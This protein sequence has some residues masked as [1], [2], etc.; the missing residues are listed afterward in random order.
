MSTGEYGSELVNVITG[1]IDT[2]SMRDVTQ[3]TIN[4]GSNFLGLNPQVDSSTNEFFPQQSG[5][6][7]YGSGHDTQ[8][9]FAGG[10]QGYQPGYIYLKEGNVYSF[11]IRFMEGGGSQRF[12]FE[13]DY[14]ED[15]S[16]SGS[17]ED[18]WRSIDGIVSVPSSGPESHEALYVSSVPFV[19]FNSNELFYDS[20]FDVLEYAAEIVK[21]DG[22]AFMGPGGTSD[23]SELGLSFN[24]STGLLSGALNSFFDNSA[25]KPRIKF[26]ATERFTPDQQSVESLVIKFKTN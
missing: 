16:G 18:N 24:T 6:G 8:I 25:M 9:F 21:A 2:T 4:S 26:S 22:S 17:W 1:T 5:V 11:Q 7:A 19:A 12:D 13:F 3:E 20:E 15:G 10:I 14:R 23:V